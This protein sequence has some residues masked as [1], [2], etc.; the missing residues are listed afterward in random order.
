VADAILDATELLLDERGL[1]GLTTN[2]IA[3]RAGVSVGSLYQYFGDKRA[4]VAEVARR[5]ERR[6]LALAQ[7]RALR[8]AVL[9][10]RAVCA[11]WVDLLLSPELG[12]PASRRALLLQIPPAWVRSAESRT[13]ES[14][15]ALL[16]QVAAALG[17]QLRPIDPE[18]RSFVSFHAVEGA[19]EC[20][21]LERPDELADPALRDEL[22][23]L[24][25]AYVAAESSRSRGASPPSSSPR[26]SEKP[27]IALRANDFASFPQEGATL[28]PPPRPDVELTPPPPAP[29]A[30]PE[31]RRAEPRSERARQTVDRI[32]EAAAGVLLDHGFDG[33]AAR[34][35]AARA[36]VSPA[37]LY[38]YFPSVQAIVAE[39]ARRRRLADAERVVAAL[40]AGAHEPLERVVR[41]VVRALVE[42]PPDS[43]L[44]Y[45]SAL[46]AALPRADYDDATRR[47]LA[48]TDPILREAFAAR[49]DELRAGSPRWTVFLTARALE[50]VLEA[51]AL[52]GRDLSSGPWIDEIAELVVRFLRAG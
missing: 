24:C 23:R 2:H 44:P 27:R 52:E 34:P 11:L 26:T 25:W 45:R 5:V 28:A 49:A 33:L 9:D 29:P 10:A 41:R 43:P 36:G 37:T 13:D 3:R 48:R 7:E 42:L 35:V 51:A 19:I 6:G 22:F 21:L 8:S 17:D 40:E 16:A 18:V 46:L 32:I 15:R 31:Q 1:R 14:V 12:P 38:R 20:V 30:R 47:V 4:I 50:R 39:I